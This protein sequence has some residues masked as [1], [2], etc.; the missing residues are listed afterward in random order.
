MSL[1]F[2]G[3]IS[4]KFIPDRE[5]RD[6]FML[7][8]MAQDAGGKTEFTSVYVVVDDV[9]DNSPQFVASGICQLVSPLGAVSP[10]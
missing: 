2:P 5:Q 6:F 3:D 1:L 8:V 10:V 9:N 4:L 7:P